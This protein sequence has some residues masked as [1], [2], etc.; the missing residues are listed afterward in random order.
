MKVAICGAAGV[1]AGFVWAAGAHAEEAKPLWEAGAGVAVINFPNYRGSD[2]RQTYALPAPYLIYRGEFLQI[3]R[4]Q[5]RGL[6]FKSERAELDV[7]VNGSVP[8]R[9]KDIAARQGMPNLD[10][11]LEIGPVLKVALMRSEDEKNVLSLRLPMRP[12]FATNF[13]HFQNVGWL[14]HP[15]LNANLR[16]AV[17]EGWNL[18]LAVGPMFADKRYHQFFYGVDPQ[19]VTAARPAYTA[20]GGYSGTQFTASLS[21]RFP[22]YWL[23]GY[24]KYDDLHGATFVDSPLVKTRQSYTVGAAVTWIF[25]ESKTLVQRE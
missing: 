2:Q 14:F 13:K 23:G 3:D 12:V 22:G 4:Q 18:G 9:S 17:G 5:A 6:F 16:D 25:A 8:V 11:T 10:P 19:Y 1:L 7:S 20:R 21:K 15:Q 24:A